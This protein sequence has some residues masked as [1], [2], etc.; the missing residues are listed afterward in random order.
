MRVD[1]AEQPIV[2][3]R[4]SIDRNAAGIQLRSEFDTLHG[5]S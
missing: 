2:I 3:V 1:K 5:I 4:R